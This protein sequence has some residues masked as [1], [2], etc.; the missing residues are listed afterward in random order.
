MISLWL[1]WT[2]TDDTGACSSPG[3]KDWTQT[4]LSVRLVASSSC[5]EA[6]PSD[7]K[8]TLLDNSHKQLTPKATLLGAKQAFIFSSDRIALI[9]VLEKERVTREY[10]LSSR[11]FTHN[12]L[13]TVSGPSM[14]FCG[15]SGRI[16]ELMTFLLEDL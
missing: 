10:G 3:E 13:S 4:Q 1:A 15:D 9:I 8:V 5:L 14:L 7:L 6:T 2:K 11:T 16:G 12:E